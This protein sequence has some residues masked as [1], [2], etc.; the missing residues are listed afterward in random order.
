MLVLN[1]RVKYVFIIIFK[2]RLI[3]FKFCREETR[4]IMTRTIKENATFFVLKEGK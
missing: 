3:K 1:L 2:I 4:Y